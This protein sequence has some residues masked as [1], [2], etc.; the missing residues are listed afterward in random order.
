MAIMTL[1]LSRLPMSARK[2]FDQVIKSETMAQIVKAKKEQREIAAFYRAHP[3]RA[4]EGIGGM[5]M[6]FDPFI[7]SALRRVCKAAPGEE[8]EIQK[9]AARKYPELRVRHLPTRLQ[10]GYGSTPEYKPKFRKTYAL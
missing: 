4:V 9:W 8:A 5:T 10:V 3:P 2:T 6:A 1:D 7:W